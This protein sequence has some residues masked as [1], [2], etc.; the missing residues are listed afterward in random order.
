[1]IKVFGIEHVGMTVPD[2]DQAVEFFETVFG[3]VTVLSTGLVD[4]DD[5]F[6]LKRLGV[7]GGRRI[8]DIRV[9]RIGNGTNIELFRY[10]GEDRNPA[11]R[12]NSET[13]AFHL[14]FQVEDANAAAVRLR[15]AGVDVLEGPT[16]I[17]SGPM[18]GLTW[19]Y[20][21]SPWG[22]FLEIVSTD[23]PLGYEREGGPK[24]WSPVDDS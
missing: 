22:Q 6:M 21:R 5:E 14:A 3:G 15:A 19:V 4:V 13:G 8:E 1:M 23:G 18:E 24:A 17:D 7:R 20:L 16:L 10:R 11:L 12:S 9:V 2:L